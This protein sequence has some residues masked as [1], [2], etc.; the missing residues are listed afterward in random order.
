MML[1]VH[2]LRALAMH[3]R[4]VVCAPRK[5]NGER[6]RERERETERE[7]EKEKD[8]ERGWLILASCGGGRLGGPPFH[9][10]ECYHTYHI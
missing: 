8:R 2:L 1:G 7:R 3:L 4:F 10:C 6:E 9:H 5:R